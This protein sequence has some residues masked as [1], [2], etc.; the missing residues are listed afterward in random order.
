M[1]THHPVSIAADSN[2]LNITVQSYEG[3]LDLGVTTC[4]DAVPDVEA[5]TN[6]LEA[7]WQALRKACEPGTLKVAA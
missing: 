2:A 5:L 3:R 6:D 7:S 4:L 1:L